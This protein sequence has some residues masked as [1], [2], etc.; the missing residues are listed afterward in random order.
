ME[1]HID[2]W[3]LIWNI[4]GSSGA[5]EAL[6]GALEAHSGEMEAYNESQRSPK[7]HPGAFRL[8]LTA[9]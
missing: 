5:L 2:S 3:R 1:A 6:P 4:G 7:A 8:N 9:V